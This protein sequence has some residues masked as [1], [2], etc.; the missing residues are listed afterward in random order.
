MFHIILISAFFVKRDTGLKNI[1]YGKTSVFKGF[2]YRLGHMFRIARKCL[3]HKGCSLSDGKGNWINGNFNNPRWRGLRFLSLF[4]GWSNLTCCK[5][6]H[7]IVMNNHFYVMIPSTRMKKMIPS[8]TVAVSIP[9]YCTN[10]HCMIGQF[11]ANRCCNS[12]SMKSVHPISVY[13]IVH[14]A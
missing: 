8:F 1:D 9:Y 5:T 2:F 11:H 4:S 12:P 14:I 3:S 10:W 7:S 6:I 13:E